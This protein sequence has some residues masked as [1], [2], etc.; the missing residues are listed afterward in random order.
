M[1]IVDGI[2]VHDMSEIKIG[3]EYVSIKY[4]MGGLGIKM[5]NDSWGILKNH[6][7]GGDSGLP[8]EV[9]QKKNTDTSFPIFSLTYLDAC[10]KYVTSASTK[11][12]D[13]LMHRNRVPGTVI[14]RNPPAAALA[15]VVGYGRLQ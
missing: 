13:T 7:V 12:T 4:M 8:Q 1:D 5:K 15:K 11:N 14:S 9:S 6:P 2:F 10:K 3:I